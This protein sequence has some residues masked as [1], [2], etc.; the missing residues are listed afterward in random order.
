MRFRTLRIAFS[1]ICLIACVLLIGLWVRSDSSFDEIGFVM[2]AQGK[3]YFL[4]DIDITPINDQPGSIESHETL[5]GLVTTLQVRNAQITRR[6]GDSPVIPFWPLILEACLVA[7]L[8][9]IRWR[10]SLRTLLIA[11]TL[12]A[13]V[14]GLVVWAARQ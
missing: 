5:G 10:F 13:V 9:W 7:V 2:S 14:L 6:P 12:V 8:P 4:P 3:L 11:T 1:A